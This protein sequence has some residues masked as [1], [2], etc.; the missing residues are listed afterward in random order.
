MHSQSVLLTG[1]RSTLGFLPR[2]H[3]DLFPFSERA[4]NP[5]PAPAARSRTTVVLSTTEGWGIVALVIAAYIAIVAALYQRGVIGPEKTISLFGPA[6]MIKTKRGRAF[7]DR[8]GRFRR[9]WTVVGDIGIFLAATSMLIIVV[10][11][12]LDAAL[13]FRLTAAQ[14]PTPQEALGLPGI[15]PI[16][17]IGYG[18]VALVVGIVLHELMHGVIAR[19]QKIG[20]K[21][22]GIL[23]LVVPVGAFVE[24][25][26]QEMIQASRR[27]R[28][29][30][31]A[32]GVLANLALAFVF[33]LALSAVVAT[34]VQA[35]HTGVGI[36]AVLPNTPAQNASL[37]AGDI[38][39]AIN[40]TT[41][42]TNNDL[43]NYLSQSVPGE[44]ISLT[45][46]SASSHHLVTTNITLTSLESYTGSKGDAKKGFLGISLTFLTP[47]QMQQSLVAPWTSSSGPVVGLTEWLV[48]PLATLEPVAGSTTSFYHLTGPLAGTDPGTFWIGAN[49]LYWLAWMDLLLGISNA[50]PLIPLDGGLLF[51]DFA[52]SIA[53]RIKRHWSADQ[54][55]RF[56]GRA[57][58]AS[59]LVV[60]LLILW[61]F[62]VPRLL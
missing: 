5:D 60:L 19:S 17:P 9:F 51:R 31:A 18:I 7:L 56:G 28:D 48:L 8:V 45:Y 37:Q 32:A 61:Q 59:S 30:V 43:L 13:S 21:S 12:V 15:N 42:T 26:D 1:K 44:N 6:L 34:S 38:I 33:F 16:I 55:D 25:D 20:V 22:L 27:T 24:Q 57:A 10:L 47:A 53:S 58:V 4:H 3:R 52:A 50:L 11:L 62:I 14:A 39:T 2:D 35:N 41:I 49:I 23:W 36:G 29:R 40:G 46:Y 54:L